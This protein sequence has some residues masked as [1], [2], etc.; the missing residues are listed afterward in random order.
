MTASCMI[1]APT[2]E[3]EG[4]R[5]RLALSVSLGSWCS[6]GQTHERPRGDGARMWARF[7]IYLKGLPVGFHWMSSPVAL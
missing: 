3:A 5:V 2:L 1:E 6:L 4:L 7:C